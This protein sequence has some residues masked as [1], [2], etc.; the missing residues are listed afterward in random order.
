MANLYE[1]F[2]AK[3]HVTAAEPFLPDILSDR[4]ES[5]AFELPPAAGRFVGGLAPEVRLAIGELVRSM[6]CHYSNLIEGDDTHPHDIDR[7]LVADYSA[8]PKQ[9][10]LQ[11]E[12]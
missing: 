10:A 3:M 7:A 9:R 6:D 4:L 1:H 2:G 12:A 8:K 5:L 11:L